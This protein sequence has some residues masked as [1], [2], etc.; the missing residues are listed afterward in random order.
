MAC[1]SKWRSFSS[2]LLFLIAPSIFAAET[3]AVVDSHVKCLLG[4][5]QNGR[6][7]TAEDALPT[8]HRSTTYRSIQP[9][10]ASS[11]ASLAN[12]ESAGGACEG[13]IAMEPSP[14][15]SDEKP[16][17]IIGGDW[18]AQPRPVRDIS[19]G[20]ARYKAA[21]NVPSATDIRQLIRTDLDGDGTDEVIAVVR[22][23]SYSAVLVRKVIGG[24][25]KTLKA[26]FETQDPSEHTVALIADLNGDGIS[27]IVV[28]GRYSQGIF[29]VV[30]ALEKNEIRK[31][32]SCACGG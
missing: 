15:P 14:A 31:V 3:F 24:E 5:V 18:T 25:V 26:T 2:A 23:S 8:L 12:P 4:G 32:L 28:H 20:R 27:E 19:A 1:T 6:W 21:L 13:T 10:G 30:Y 29:T 22:T 16:F 11:I 9:S 7:L 17:I